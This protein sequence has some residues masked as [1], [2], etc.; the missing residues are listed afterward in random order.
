VN[1]DAIEVSG[2]GFCYFALVGRG[3]L[4]TAGELV[5]QQLNRD[6]CAVIADETSARLF[7]NS[8]CESFRS[9]NFLPHLIRI[10][11]G[12]K[13][14]SLTRVETICD[15]MIEAGLDRSSFV[16]GLGGGVIGDISGFVASIFQR[17]VPHVQIPTTLLAMID[18]SIGGKTGVNLSAGKNLIGTI[19]HPALII[20]DVET[21]E[22]LPPRE[23][24][25][26]YAEIIKHAVIRDADMFYDLSSGAKQNKVER[27]GGTS[28]RSQRDST[29]SA[30]DDRLVAL[31]RR[32]IAIKAGI[33]STDARELVGERALLNFGHTIGHAIERAADF[34]I[35]HGDCV[36]IGMVAACN[37]SIKRAE[38][39]VE[40]RDALVTLLKHFELPTR[41]PDEV[42][43]QKAVAAVAHDKKF[44]G[45]E[46]RFV[47]TPRIGEAR[48]S[49]EVTMG[50]IR[51]AI[52]EL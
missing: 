48:V 8:V 22:S 23:L 32:N 34:R 31:I 1:S 2:N 37:I 10:P 3:L 17:G 27:S 45:G 38:F 24:R 46:V 42:N 28:L 49:N 4:T 9:Q 5:R 16:V 41:L 43:R 18:S 36:S 14:K 30:R 47:V 51:D 7:G 15:E 40:E 21:L 11:A 29:V 26:G 52:S 20:A 6:C 13:S 19:H 35:P 25:Q 44:V 50:D 12:E 33:V 39:S